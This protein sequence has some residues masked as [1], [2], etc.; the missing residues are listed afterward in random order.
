MKTKRLKGR[1][2]RLLMDKVASDASVSVQTNFNETLE[3]VWQKLFY[4]L[5]DRWSDTWLSRKSAPVDWLSFNFWSELISW[6]VDCHSIC[7]HLHFPSIWLEWEEAA[8]ID[9]HWRPHNE[10]L[11]NA[12]CI[13]KMSSMDAAILGRPFC[14]HPVIG[15]VHCESCSSRMAQKKRGR[16]A[17]C[18]PLNG[19][20]NAKA[21][22]SSYSKEEMSHFV[23]TEAK[24]G[25]APKKI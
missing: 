14:R 7:G 13:S 10:R 9:S 21:N 2:G 5:I 22:N 19:S 11:V 18:T 17:V 25:A 16:P 1:K 4:R 23:P 12:H 20:I 6:R 24:G 15:H 3:S 8:V